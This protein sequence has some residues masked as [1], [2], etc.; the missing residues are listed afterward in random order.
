MN[1]KSSLEIKLIDFG[2]SYEW[3]NNMQEELIK[4]KKNKL[5]G[6]S[7]YIAPEVFLF[8]IERS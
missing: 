3:E 7:Y 6:T 8:D 5:A 2:L 4:Q 1:S